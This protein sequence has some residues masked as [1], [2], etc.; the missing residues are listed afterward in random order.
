MN[1]LEIYAGFLKKFLKPGKKVKAVFDCS[2]GSVGPVLKKVFNGHPS[3]TAYYLNSSPDGNF[4]GHGPNPLK[5]NAFRALQ[6]AVLKKKADLGAIFDADGDRV[7]FVD[8]KGRAIDSDIVVYFL[9][10]KAGFGP[11]YLVDIAE[12]KGPLVWI[13]PNIK[14]LE[15]KTG[16][17]FIKKLMREKRIEFGAE[18]SGHYYFKDF[19]YC[20]SG[21]L[22]AIRFVNAASS[23]PYKLSDFVDFL[24]QHFTSRE[25]NFKVSDPARTVKRVKKYILRRYRNSLKRVRE[26]E[27]IRE[28]ALNAEFAD[29]WLS[30]R[31]SNT[32]A[33]IRLNIEALQKK[34]L[35]EKIAEFRKIISAG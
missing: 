28:N 13:A 16:H 2:N 22:A 14:I 10:L 35:L 9:I 30:L 6:L 11:P 5:Q 21:V 17:Y 27:L 34:L 18:H 15:T 1:Y 12:G 29:W 26:A 33:L 3:L 24:P 19:F 31:P 20:D 25:I 23:L 32:E 4:P 7:F 8:N